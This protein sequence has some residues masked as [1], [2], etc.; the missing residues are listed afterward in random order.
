MTSPGVGSLFGRCVARALDRFWHELGEP[1]PY[2]VVDAGAG[3]GELARDVLR[4]RPE[5]T[6]ALR[7]V[8]VERS[9]PLRAEQRARLPVEPPDEALGPFVRTA[10][11]DAPVPATGAGPVVAS[12]G[13]LPA[14][15]APAAVV[16]AN[17]LLDNLPFGI[18]DFDGTNWSEVRV[19]LDGD[20]FVEVLVPLPDP[21]SVDLAAPGR[22]PIPRGLRAWFEECGTVLRRGFVV[23]I[24]YFTDSPELRLRT[25]RGHERGFDPLDAPGTRD[26]TADVVAS[27]LRAAARG[28]TVVEDTTQAA[29][30]R[31]LGIDDLAAEGARRWRAGAHRGDLEALAG[32]SLVHEAAVLTDPAGFGAHRVVVLRREPP[33]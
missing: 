21:P 32:R 19:G 3:R 22:V 20:R 1:D 9:A 8:L 15:D 12:L 30:L 10:G 23:V 14:V 29:W 18:A 13:T 7:Y 28:F 2:L 25:Y 33:G 16:L 4:S 17:E 31:A 5:C 6:A 27:Q 26:I 24:D 11:E